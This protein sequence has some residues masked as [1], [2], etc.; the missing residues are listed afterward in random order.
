MIKLGADEIKFITLFEARTGATVKD[1][2]IEEDGITFIVK[3]G[4]TGLAIG[5][6]GAI[7]NRI[8]QEIG[9]ELHVYEHSENPEKFISNLL[10]PVKVEKV[11]INGNEAKVYINPAE[12][13]RAIG[14]GGK[15]INT[16][17]ALAS[18]HFGIENITVV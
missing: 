8:K 15:K 14:K 11:E 10:F 1:C 12:K 3:E 9:K 18:R 13:K 6:K 7:I 4:D 5:K 16:V 2:V 17:R